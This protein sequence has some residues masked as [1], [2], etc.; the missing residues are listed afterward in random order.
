MLDLYFSNPL[1]EVA[2]RVAGFDAGL[3]I[4]DAAFQ[5]ILTKSAFKITVLD[6]TFRHFIKT[7][8]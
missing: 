3:E 4:F 6:A 7:Y 5:I 8:F 1:F 2:L